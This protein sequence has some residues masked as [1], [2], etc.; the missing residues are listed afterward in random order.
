MRGTGEVTA[1]ARVRGGTG[2]DAVEGALRGAP[3]SA[4][5]QGRRPHHCMH[6]CMHAYRALL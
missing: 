1:A 5:Q 4:G 3:D 2:I 6:A